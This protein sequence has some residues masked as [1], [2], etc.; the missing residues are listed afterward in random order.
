M[1]NTRHGE[2][3]NLLNAI[4]DSP[5]QIIL[6][7]IADVQRSFRVVRRNYDELMEAISAFQNEKVI[8]QLWRQESRDVRQEAMEVISTR[9]HNF[10]AAAFSLVDHARRH[11]RHLYSE[12]GFNEEIDAQ[13]Q[14]LILGRP[15]HGIAQGLR[16]Y[17][18][19]V[20]PP[21]INFVLEGRG[22]ELIGSKFRLSKENL[23]KW[24]RWKAQARRS[25]EGRADDITVDE[26]I[27]AYFN[28]VSEFYGWL[29]RRQEEVHSE[30]IE[31]ANM[32]RDETRALHEELYGP[33]NKHKG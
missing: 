33:I 13:L 18:L 4:Q 17:A 6:N 30:E 15:E 21:I 31:A 2:L 22:G 5:G 16:D 9:L 3:M 8:S 26:F 32:L 28:Q 29:W 27:E 14:S 25:I 10:L 1:A 20:G 11:R 23:L 19:H 12:G 24:D 7:E